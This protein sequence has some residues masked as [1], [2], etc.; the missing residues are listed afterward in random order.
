MPLCNH[1]LLCSY[2]N[3]PSLAHLLL[4]PHLLLLFFTLNSPWLI[5]KVM[6]SVG[7]L[8]SKQKGGFVESPFLGFPVRLVNEGVKGVNG[9]ESAVLASAGLG[10]GPCPPFYLMDWKGVMLEP[11]LPPVLASTVAWTSVDAR[12]PSAPSSMLW[13]RTCMDSPL[14][15]PGERAGGW[16]GCDQTAEESWFVIARMKVW[17]DTNTSVAL[18]VAP[19]CTRISQVTHKVTAARVKS[20][21]DHRSPA[22]NASKPE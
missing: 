11:G 22:K 17:W 18:K 15:L 5:Q 1:H 8:D 10:K 4:S 13:R 21:H 7:Q 20:Q 3:F 9:F 2:G 16:Q 6:R 12:Q 19:G 14:P